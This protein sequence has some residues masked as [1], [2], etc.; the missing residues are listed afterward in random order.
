[1]PAGRLLSNQ[2]GSSAGT[3]CESQKG[4][5]K[6]MYPGGSR[7]ENVC[8]PDHKQY[9]LGLNEGCALRGLEKIG[10][11]RPCKRYWAPIFRQNSESHHTKTEG[12]TVAP[13]PK[14]RCCSGPKNER[15]GGQRRRVTH[16]RSGGQ[17]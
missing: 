4:T 12:S 3:N 14:N 8:R 13:T 11:Q 2:E 7:V 17:G 5:E 16:Q 1:M 15:S 9:P 6:R 10:I